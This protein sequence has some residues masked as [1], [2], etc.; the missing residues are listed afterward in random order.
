VDEGRM[1]S[2]AGIVVWEQKADLENREFRN[3]E[4]GRS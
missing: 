2:L 1:I 3:F 4:K